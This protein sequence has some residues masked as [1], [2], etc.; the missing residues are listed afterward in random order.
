MFQIAL[1][2]DIEDV[3]FLNPNY[4]DQQLTA[5][6][7]DDMAGII[8]EG[9][10]I[11]RDPSEDGLDDGSGEISIGGEG[12]G[13]AED[14]ASVVPVTSRPK[15]ERE[16]DPMDGWF[17]GK[18]KAE[19]YRTLFDDLG[20]RDHFFQAKIGRTDPM[21]KDCEKLLYSISFLTFQV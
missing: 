12:S 7:M 15:P 16:S 6:E 2:P 19:E 18:D 11:G 20:C 14:S 13:D 5:G 17:P 21:P 10:I 1:L 4:Q 8:G 9:M 3:P